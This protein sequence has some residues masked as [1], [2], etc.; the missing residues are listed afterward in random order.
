M[1]GIL[2]AGPL[3]LGGV[4]V[5]PFLIIQGLTLG[6]MGLWAVRIWLH[7]SPRILF[8]PVCWPVLAFAAYAIGRYYTADI[9]YVARQELSRILV[10][11]FLFFAV[12]NNLHR[13][14]SVQV[15]TFTLLGLGM[16]IAGLAIYQFISGS[17][18]VW[19]LFKLY[20]GR[21]TGTYMNPNHLGGFLE[22][23]LPLALSTAL[24]ARFK[25]LTRI[26]VGYTGL[27]I[28]A[29]LGVT[30]SR[31]AWAAAFFGLLLLCGALMFYRQYRLPV[32]I[33][34]VAVCGASAIFVQTSPLTKLRLKQIF[35]SKGG[36][37]DNMRLSLWKPAFQ[38]WQQNPWWGAGPA[39]FDYR[40]RAFRPI[41]VQK[42]PD[43][44]HNDYV[45]TLADWGIVGFG[46]LASIW[47]TL[48]FTL[49]RT[50]PYVRG[51]STELGDQK[52]ST[53]FSFVLGAGIGLASLMLHSWVDF[54]WHIPA[55]AIIAVTF[56]AVL[57]SFT[58]FATEGYWFRAGVGLRC[59]VT[60]VLVSGLVWLGGRG[61]RMARS[62]VW[63]EKASQAPL[64]STEH[65]GL[66]KKA[67][68]IDPR[69]FE[70][71]Y[72]IGEALRTQSSEGGRN[73]RE[74]AKQAIEFFQIGINF[75][76][77]D[78]YQQLRAGFCLDWLDR[79]S[80]ADAYFARAEALDPNGAFMMA[81]IGIRYVQL[82][83]YAAARPWLER[84]TRLEW[85]GNP[86]P[87]NYLK[88]CEARLAEAATNSVS[89]VRP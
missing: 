58:R 26:L 43:R 75:N 18:R 49:Y 89:R 40:F 80:E 35:T 28:L 14:E 61:V 29:G 31:G 9:E 83:E 88:I 50:W 59:L 86:L 52:G 48:C 67:Y 81:Q 27:V 74:L 63:L 47:G 72:A 51:A 54:N 5:V 4:G 1:L 20:K 3:A 15:I 70:T 66:L 65:V 34:L 79:R 78:G 62:Q 8:P 22:L 13:R 41:N 55:N 57:T 19:H 76:P 82:G 21:G 2:V 24:L 17:D 36:V 23:L 84:S 38:I 7:P 39:H 69:N 12:L 44:A 71:T 42:R 77:W 60:L 10:Y 11:T 46:L 16:L 56:M 85:E 30:L 87:H 73:Y 45:N 53:K 33:L 6:V 32:I 64:Y 25:P 37:D 68:E